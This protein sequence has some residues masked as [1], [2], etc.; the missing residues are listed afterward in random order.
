[1]LYDNSVYWFEEPP[2]SLWFSTTVSEVVEN[3]IVNTVA[4]MKTIVGRDLTSRKLTDVMEQ[5]KNE[6]I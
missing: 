6:F 2:Y 5:K 1:V 3:I 4:R